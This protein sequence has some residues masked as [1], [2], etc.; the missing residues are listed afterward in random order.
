[1]V[2]DE[3]PEPPATPTTVYNTPK[4]GAYGGPISPPADLAPNVRALLMDYRWA[5]AFNGPIP[6]SALNSE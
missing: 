5:T 2:E 4:G 3:S 6:A 1:M